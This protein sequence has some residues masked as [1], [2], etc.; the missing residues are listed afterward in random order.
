MGFPLP[1]EHRNMPMQDAMMLV[2][3]NYDTYKVENREKEREEIARKA[4]KMADDVLLREPDRESH[5]ISVL[6]TITLLSENRYFNQQL[7]MCLQINSRR[8]SVQVSLLVCSLCRFVTPEELDTL[9]AYLKD[10]R[11]RLLRSTADPLAGRCKHLILC[12]KTAN[13]AT[14]LSFC[15]KLS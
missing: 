9:S 15:F 14:Y 10:K 5:P 3:H 8:T 7:E 12:L 2:A 1:I 11:T 4:A 13:S 6:T